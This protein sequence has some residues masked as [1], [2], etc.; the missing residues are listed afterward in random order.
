MLGMLKR[1]TLDPGISDQ[2]TEISI[3]GIPNHLHRKINST[4]KHH[5]H[6]V[7]VDVSVPVKRFRSIK[8]KQS[9]KER[10]KKVKSEFIRFYGAH[11]G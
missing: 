8:S 6:K 1:F 9:S 3:I 5:L 2:F 10:R 4:S 7:H 11:I